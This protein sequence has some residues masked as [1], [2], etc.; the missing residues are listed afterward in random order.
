ML[1]MAL[2]K[3]AQL[4]T[5]EALFPATRAD[6]RISASLPLYPPHA[7]IVWSVPPFDSAR[8]CPPPEGQTKGP[9]FLPETL[10]IALVST[11][12]A[13][14]GPQGSEGSGR[15][16]SS[17]KQGPILESSP[18]LST[19]H[20]SH[21]KCELRQVET[22]TVPWKTLQSPFGITYFALDYTIYQGPLNS[23]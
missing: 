14:G 11:R 20:R 6:A 19:T 22:R 12:Q 21:R 16:K 5:P 9:Q 2:P 7:P 18:T 13:K 3:V 17:R 23:L 10:D 1:K 8:A 4:L 15:G